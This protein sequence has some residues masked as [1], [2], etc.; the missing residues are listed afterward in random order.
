MLR[1]LILSVSAF[2]LTAGCS[3]AQP[4]LPLPDAKAVKVN[5]TFAMSNGV[6]VT[7]NAPASKVWDILTNAADYANWNSTVV[8]I[9][10][11]IRYDE[12]I[13]L[14]AKIAPEREF[15]IEVSTFEKPSKMVWEDGNFMFR[16]VRTFTLTAVEPNKTR[17]RMVEEFSGLML[18]M[19]K[20]SLPDFGPAFEQFALDL[21]KKAES[22]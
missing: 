13:V 14:K 12:E 10:G 6:A 22:P 20:G 11:N 21:K 17:F 8:Y 7:I 16:G 1:L 9:K 4:K 18:P 5:H 3:S 19:I 15:E 2:L